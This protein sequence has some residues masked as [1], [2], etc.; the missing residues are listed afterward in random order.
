MLAR[1]IKI[2][3][4]LSMMTCEL[5]RLFWQE[6]H[7][8]SPTVSVRTHRNPPIGFVGLILSSMT[9]L[10]KI[11]KLTKT[12]AATNSRQHSLIFLIVSEVACELRPKVLAHFVELF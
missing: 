1:F 3:L 6:K 10:K 2:P 5:S 11:L 9:I 4:I 12:L 8:S 7:E